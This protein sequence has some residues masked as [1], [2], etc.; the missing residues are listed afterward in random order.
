MLN[1]LG[2]VHFGS[3][4]KVDTFVDEGIPI[5]NGQQLRGLMLEDSSFNFISLEHAEKLKNANVYPGDIVLTHR[6]TLGQVALIPNN[7]KYKRYIVSQSQFFVRCNLE[8]I[9]P[10]FLIYYLR[11]PEGQHKLLANR[12]AVGVPAIAQPVTYLR[13]IKLAVPPKELLDAFEQIVAPLHS[14]YSAN[15]QESRTLAS[16]RDSLLPKL[17]RGEVSVSAP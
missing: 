15:W 4:I 2:W 1:V 9:T 3:S 17:M 5:I 13:S 6:G 10:N 16:L 14:K 11:S 8:K 7:A 12:S